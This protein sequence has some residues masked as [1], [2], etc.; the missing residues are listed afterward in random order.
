M[1]GV[2]TGGR[3]SCTEQPAGRAPKHAYA[4]SPARRSLPAASWPA[5]GPGQGVCRPRSGADNASGFAVAG[6]DPVNAK[7]PSGLD[8]A[9]GPT[10]P[11]ALAN[12][13]SAY[14]GFELEQYASAV[15]KYK[16]GKA[17]ENYAN[18]V[19]AYQMSTL[20][21][22]G[23]TPKVI[24]ESE[25]DTPQ[26]QYFGGGLVLGGGGLAGAGVE[27]FVGE[28]GI[29]ALGA[30]GASVPIVGGLALIGWGIYELW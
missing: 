23:A 26:S 22:A 27:Y 13:A 1:R 29:T 18:A 19:D 5:N 3:R 11:V 12:F 2:A 10:T 4:P 25:K 7:D 8:C 28:A 24:K 20:N 30:L 17:L 21:G 15:E 16:A 6:D 9:G 14:G